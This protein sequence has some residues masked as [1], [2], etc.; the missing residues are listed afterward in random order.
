MYKDYDRIMKELNAKRE[1]WENDRKKVTTGLRVAED[2]LRALENKRDN[3][4]TEDEYNTA[5]REI[6]A[7][8]NYVDFLK[9]RHRTLP[10]TR[11]LTREELSGIKKS[12]DK[13]LKEEQ[14]KRAGEIAKALNKVIDLMNDY[15]SITE[16]LSEVHSLASYLATNS[17]NAS[18]GRQ[19]I[20]EAVEDPYDWFMLFTQ[21]YFKQYDVLKYTADHIDTILNGG[22]TLWSNYDINQV[23]YAKNMK[24]G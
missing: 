21:M 7:K 24:K 3:A 11:P 16:D 23:R 1:T 4:T 2:E 5:V 14:R 17:T 8:R 20:A 10:K 15:A 12:I 22:R 19:G 9:R 6:E 13:D 18:I